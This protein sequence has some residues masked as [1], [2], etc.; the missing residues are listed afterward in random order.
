MVLNQNVFTNISL[1][2]YV[3]RHLAVLQFMITFHIFRSNNLTEFIC[4]SI[5]FICQDCVLHVC[6]YYIFRLSYYIFWSFFWP[7]F[8]PILIYCF[9]SVLSDT[10]RPTESPVV[11]HRVLVRP[12]AHVMNACVAYGEALLHDVVHEV[13]PQVHLL[14]IITRPKRKR[15]LALSGVHHVFTPLCEIFADPLQE[16]VCLGGDRELRDYHGYGVGIFREFPGAREFHNLLKDVWRVERPGVLK[17]LDQ[18]FDLVEVRLF[19]QQ[20]FFGKVR[21]KRQLGRSKKVQDVPE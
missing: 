6:M 20:V 21:G 9:F 16:C 3:S 10:R 4:I 2:I 5:N 8:W 1:S 15:H 7:I 17:A 12:L 14:V 13:H 11:L 18:R 19:P